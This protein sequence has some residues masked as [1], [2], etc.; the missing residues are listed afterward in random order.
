MET[1]TKML[2]HIYSNSKEIMVCGHCGHITSAVDIEIEAYDGIIWE[3][4]CLNC[5][6][7]GEIIEVD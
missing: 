5:R 2:K 6:R 7:V 4:I 3:A 1:Q